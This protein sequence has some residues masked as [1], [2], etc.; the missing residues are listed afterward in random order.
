MNG[1]Y[2]A[3][4]RVV[5]MVDGQR[6]EFAPGAMLPE[7]PASDVEALLDMHAITAAHP[8][9]P[10]PDLMGATHDPAPVAD[11]ADTEIPGAIAPTEAGS[12]TSEPGPAGGASPGTHT[13]TEGRSSGF[14]ARASNPVDELDEPL[15]AIDDAG[16]APGAQNLSVTLAPVN[17]NTVTAERLVSLGL[18]E[19]QALAVITHR[20]SVGD[21]AAVEH[22]TRVTGIGKATLDRI[23]HALNV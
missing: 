17:L 2:I 20:E 15:P 5:A 23:A 4:V 12:T 10:L 11:V 14:E 19:Q 8:E 18:S 22:I 13:T 9:V 21:F 3:L 6:R 16:Y 1:P 7:L